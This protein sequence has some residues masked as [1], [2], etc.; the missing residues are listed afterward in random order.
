[1]SDTRDLTELLLGIRFPHRARTDP[2]VETPSK[3]VKAVTTAREDEDPFGP[4]VREI[5]QGIRVDRNWTSIC[6]RLR[7][8]LLRFFTHRGFP[9]TEAEDLCQEVLCKVFRGIQSFEGRSRFSCWVFEIARN[10]YANEVRGRQADRRKG[11]EIPL[12]EERGSE[13]D[14]QHGRAPALVAA[15]PS[16]YENAEIEEQLARLRAALETLPPQMRQCF[17]LRFYQGLKFREVAAVMNVSLDTVKAHLGEAR[18]RLRKLL[19]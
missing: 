15:D 19:S 9:P 7:P 13:E 3:G 5:Q 6:E 1:M 18:K 14:D 16:P 2:A 12:L 10:H 17:M 11:R 4:V 8:Q